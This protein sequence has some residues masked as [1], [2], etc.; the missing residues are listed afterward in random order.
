MSV[1]E[2][3]KTRVLQEYR[4]IVQ[5]LRALMR[6]CVPDTEEMIGP[7]KN[8]ITFAFSLGSRTSAACWRAWAGSR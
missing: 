6:H 3:V 2:P 4:G 1:D 7:T 5:E 8:G